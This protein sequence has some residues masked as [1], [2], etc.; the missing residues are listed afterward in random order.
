MTHPGPW[1]IDQETENAGDVIDANGGP[2]IFGHGNPPRC[3][4]V[5]GDTRM[6]STEVAERLVLAAPEL[7]DAFKKATEFM[8]SVAPPEWMQFAHGLIRQIEQDN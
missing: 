3:L 5:K 8:A 1:R 7:L 6:F 4:A 2:V